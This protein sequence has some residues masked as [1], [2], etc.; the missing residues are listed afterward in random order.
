MTTEIHPKLA[1]YRVMWRADLS[2]RWILMKEADTREEADQFALEALHAH[3][4]YCR[5]I[6]QFVI[7]ESERPRAWE[8]PNVP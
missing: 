4:G 7:H 6:S 1:P 2:T 3:G 5:L 8:G